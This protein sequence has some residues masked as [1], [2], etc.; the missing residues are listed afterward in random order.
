MIQ[1]IQNTIKSVKGKLGQQKYTFELL[2]FDF[3]LDE[4]LAT[5]LIEVNTNPCLEEQRALNQ[6]LNDECLTLELVSVLSR[7]QHCRHILLVRLEY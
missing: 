4:E 6:L 3:I 2:G 7:I 5:T 1:I